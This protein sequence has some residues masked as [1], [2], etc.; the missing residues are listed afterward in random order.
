MCD[1]PPGVEIGDGESDK[2]LVE[3]ES[4]RILLDFWWS[5]GIQVEEDAMV[6]RGGRVGRRGSSNS[7]DDSAGEALSLEVAIGDDIRDRLL[8]DFFDIG[9]CDA[10]SNPGTQFA[11]PDL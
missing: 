2:E 6:A 11:L 4:G 9:E 1:V 5:G 10:Y 7:T 3:E 8:E